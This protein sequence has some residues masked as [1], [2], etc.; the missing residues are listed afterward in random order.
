MRGKIR[1]CV[2]VAAAVCGFSK[3]ARRL[4]TAIPA[5]D[6]SLVRSWRMKDENE[7]EDEDEKYQTI[8]L[9]RE[10][11]CSANPNVSIDF[12]LINFYFLSSFLCI[13]VPLLTSSFIRAVHFFRRLGI[14]SEERQMMTPPVRPTPN[15]AK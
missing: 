12:V 9:N 5:D 11:S 3:G 13:H 15:V 6:P 7:D 1:G 4:A 8:V 14:S 10:T 2:C